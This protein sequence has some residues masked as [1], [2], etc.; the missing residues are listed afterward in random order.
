MAAL[1]S[2]LGDV[3]QKASVLS[4]G[5]KRRLAYFRGFRGFGRIYC[6]ESL[7]DSSPNR[8]PGIAALR[9]DTVRE[10]T[11]AAASPQTPGLGGNR[12]RA[13]L[14]VLRRGQAENRLRS[15]LS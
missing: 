13:P 10:G 4:L 8:V 2:L 9:A 11:L 6:G 7:R 15:R 12:L 1:R 3:F 5:P 14:V